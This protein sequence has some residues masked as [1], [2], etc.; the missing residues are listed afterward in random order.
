MNAE[1]V[2]RALGRNLVEGLFP[3][4]RQL[5]PNLNDIYW[6]ELAYYENL[7]LFNAE[8]VRNAA[9]FAQVGNQYTHH[10]LMCAGESGKLTDPENI[11]RGL[12]QKSRYIRLNCIDRTDIFSY[13]LYAMQANSIIG[14]AQWK[15]R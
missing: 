7:I 1:T 12:R 14:G 10:F 15:K 8:L 6:M 3:S 13:I 11:L 9:Y 4:D 2:V 5:I